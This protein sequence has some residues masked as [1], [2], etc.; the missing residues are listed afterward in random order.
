MPKV[1]D[2]AKDKVKNEW[3]TGRTPKAS[4]LN[5]T[6][7]GKPACEYDHY[8]GY[9]KEHWL[10]VEPV[11]RSCHHKRGFKRGERDQQLKILQ[12][13]SRQR[14]LEYRVWRDNIRGNQ[15]KEEQINL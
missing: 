3:R 4:Q 12:E 7:C 13:L 5:C 2:Q 9:A 8:L 14:W 11:C 1:K 10:D 15:T 6:D